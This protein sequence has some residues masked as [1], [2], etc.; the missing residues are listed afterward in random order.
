MNRKSQPADFVFLIPGAAGHWAQG[1]EAGPALL[2]CLI[3][4]RYLLYISS[5]L[6]DAVCPF[7]RA[8]GLY[9]VVRIYLEINLINKNFNMERHS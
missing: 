5:L 3:R 6:N 9:A 2:L 4:N 7:I 8:D 1:A